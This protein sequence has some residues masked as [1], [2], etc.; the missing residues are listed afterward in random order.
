MGNRLYTICSLVWIIYRRLQVKHKIKWLFGILTLLCAFQ[1]HACN[2]IEKPLIEFKKKLN[3]LSTELNSSIITISRKKSSFTYAGSGVTQESQ[4][5]IG[6]VTKQMTAFMLLNVLQQKFPEKNL[7]KLLKQNILVTFPNSEF[8]NAINKP[9]LSKISLMD[10]LTHR[11]GLSDYTMYY[12][13]DLGKPELLNN[14]LNPVEIIQSIAFNPQKKYDYSN[15][16]YLL[17]GK[18]I[19]EVGQS[20]FNQLFDKYIKT[21]GKMKLSHAPVMGNYHYLKNKPDFYNL[22]PNLN[23]TIFFDLS[24]AIGTGNVISSTADLIKWNNYFHKKA[25]PELRKIM[26]KNYFQDEDGGW[27][28]LGLSTEPTDYGPLIGFQGH[29]D[30]YYSFLGFLPDYDLAI[31]FLSNNEEDFE[32]L[33]DAMENFLR[34]KAA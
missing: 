7:K 20:S 31:T 29:L 21:P 15:T 16:N 9:W 25:N 17:L 23:S 30:S 6:S 10:L 14:P 22:L 32:K 5:Y 28:N 3:K 13:K 27:D 12:E 1:L 26:L 8:L 19:E 2:P 24:N 18:L 33:M 34:K 4:F 11:S